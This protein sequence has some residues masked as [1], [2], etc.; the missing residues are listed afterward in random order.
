M[1]KRADVPLAL[2]RS[3]GL[4]PTEGGRGAETRER[5]LD[6]AERIF[7]ERGFEGAS[8]RAV[9]QAAGA[10]V[11][12]ANYHF[13]SKA[14][15]LRATLLRRV[16]PLN[17]RRL[18][19]LDALEENASGRPLELE[20]I[21]DAFL[22]PVFEEHAASADATARFRQVAARIY[23]D[24][25]DVVAAIKKELF[26]PIVVRFVGALSA[27]LPEKSREEI[28]L[29]FQL[30]V[31]VMV[32]VISGHLVTVPGP[33]DDACECWTSRLSNESVLQQMIAYVVAGLRAEVKS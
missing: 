22:R 15:L 32:H 28:E 26:G 12:A 3:A 13:G 31:G 30:T 16:G 11:S 1:P 2:S 5:L 10:S 20:T 9:T 25:P 6:A 4:A 17:E 14:A 27:A 24:P 8:M 23:S 29:G 18:E 21:I 33:E 19:R 7:A